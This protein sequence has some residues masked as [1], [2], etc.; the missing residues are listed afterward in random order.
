MKF[1]NIL[2]IEETISS[3]DVIAINRKKDFVFT[4]DPTVRI[5]Q[6]DSTC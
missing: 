5:K 2:G 1:T 4:I 3:G 6:R